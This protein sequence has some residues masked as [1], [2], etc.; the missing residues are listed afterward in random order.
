MVELCKRKTTDLK[1]DALVL[2]IITVGK[3]TY[4]SSRRSSYLGISRVGVEDV[5]EELARACDARNNQSV[6]VEAVDDEI[7]RRPV[8]GG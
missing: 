4:E 6:D 3:K 7:R 1:Y 5:G 2:L 8:D